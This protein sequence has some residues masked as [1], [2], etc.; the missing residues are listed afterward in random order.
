MSEVLGAAGA[1]LYHFFPVPPAAP[2]AETPAPAKS[3]LVIP[4]RARARKE[5]RPAE[6]P[7]IQTAPSISMLTIL[8]VYK[9][10]SHYREQKEQVEGKM[11]SR[12]RPR[13][14]DHFN[15]ARNGGFG[16]Y[17]KNMNLV[18]QI[19]F[20]HC[21]ELPSHVQENLP[22]DRLTGKHA[23]I[24]GLLVSK[25]YTKATDKATGEKLQVGAKLLNKTINKL[26]IDGYTD[27]HARV[28]VANEGSLHRFKDTGF[29]VIGDPAPSPLHPHEQ[30]YFLHL[31]LTPHREKYFGPKPQPKP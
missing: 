5:E 10:E 18:G 16:A 31:N 19:L 24:E 1:K 13:L 30:V 25:D 21:K 27:V 3:A 20:T 12:S 4:F 7:N 23:L 14:Q 8:N 29:V 22:T 2:R 17:D 11:V 28:R 15:D 6:I 26:V 9:L